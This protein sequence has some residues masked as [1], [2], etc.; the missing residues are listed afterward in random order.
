MFKDL[1]VFEVIHSGGATIYILILCSVVSIA[2]ILERIL[3]YQRRGKTL[4]ISLMEAIRRE[5][6][7]GQMLNAVGL[8]R[9]N[10]SPCAKVALAGLNLNGHD[11]KLIA[12]A[13]EREI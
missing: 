8:C 9:N 1:N 5:I 13:M 6:A 11:E 2:V 3:Y 4:R 7:K 10:D 12:N